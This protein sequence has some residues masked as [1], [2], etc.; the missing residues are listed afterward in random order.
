M[1]TKCGT[2]ERLRWPASEGY[3]VSRSSKGLQTASAKSMMRQRSQ[4]QPSQAVTR[5]G[6]K[7]PDKSPSVYRC[8]GAALKCSG[9]IRVGRST[10]GDSQTMKLLRHPWQRYGFFGQR[11]GLSHIDYVRSHRKASASDPGNGN[12]MEKSAL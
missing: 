7:W 11:Y 1:R 10:E 8:F 3:G 6:R 2:P 5:A 9:S 4:N 12:G